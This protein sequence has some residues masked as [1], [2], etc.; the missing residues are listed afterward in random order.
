MEV[1]QTERERLKGTKKTWGE[2]FVWR[3]DSRSKV[4]TGLVT[5]GERQKESDTKALVEYNNSH[6]RVCVY[7]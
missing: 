2:D 4:K 7:I 3:T 6:E 1:V 5:A